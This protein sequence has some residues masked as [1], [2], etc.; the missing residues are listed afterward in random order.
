MTQR[1][2]SDEEIDKAL[3]GGGIVFRKASAASAQPQGVKTKAKKKTY[4]RGTHGS[5]AAKHKAEIR[6]RRAARPSQRKS[7]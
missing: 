2:A 1:K 4:I 3:S 5:A 6:R 7:Q